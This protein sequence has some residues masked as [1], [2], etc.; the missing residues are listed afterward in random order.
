MIS[1]LPGVRLQYN[2][3][4][5]GNLL[6]VVH[7]Y[8]S[9]EAMGFAVSAGLCIVEDRVVISGLGEVELLQK[10]NDVGMGSDC[11]GHI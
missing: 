9:A 2:V 5:I 8:A 6:E 4:G 7:K 1:T 10:N 11:L 3:A